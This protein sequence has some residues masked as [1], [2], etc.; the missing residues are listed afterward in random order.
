MRKY[1]LAKQIAII[2]ALIIS[3]APH[4]PT[5]LLEGQ[6]TY[7]YPP[8]EGDSWV[9]AFGDVE[10]D[11]SFT[12]THNIYLDI[13]RGT[14]GT[15]ILWERS[16]SVML[17]GY[18][19]Y[20][21]YTIL[22]NWSVINYR[23]PDLSI[24]IEYR[25]PVPYVFHPRSPND[26]MSI[27]SSL[28]LYLETPNGT[29]VMKGSQA[30][31]Y[32]V[33]GTTWIIYN[34]TMI[35]AYVVQQYTMISLVNMEYNISTTTIT[36]GAYI[37]NNSFKLP[38]VSEFTTETSY[39][40]GEQ[41]TSTSKMIL[42]S[43]RIT[44]DPLVPATQKPSDTNTTTT[45][46]PTT[47]AKEVTTPTPTETYTSVPSPTATIPANTIVQTYNLLIIVSKIGNYSGPDVP[48]RIRIQNLANGDTVALVR[49]NGTYSIKLPSSTYVLSIE[50]LEGRGGDGAYYYRF[51]EWKIPVDGASKT[52]QDPLIQVKLDRDLAIT[53]IVEVYIKSQSKVTPAQTQT[54]V[55]TTARDTTTTTAPNLTR[56]QTA[57]VEPL[58]TARSPIY[59]G[60]E[61]GAPQIPLEAP[62]KPWYSNPIIIGSIAG[63][64][65][66]AL[67][68]AIV[69][70]R[71]N[72]K[73]GG[74][75]EI[76]VLDK[77]K[78]AQQPPA[79]HSAS[80]Q[81]GRELPQAGQPSGASL[82]I[83]SRCGASNPLQARF[84]RQCGAELL[85]SKD[86]K[87]CPRCGASIKQGARFCPRCGSPI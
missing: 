66:A 6:A 21:N 48:V 82:Q 47:T 3:I 51:V 13:S 39:S 52:Y 29:M 65:A 56:T 32:A 20:A 9:Y 17:E 62:E 12:H 54:G 14:G 16:E 68:A 55:I 11:G 86:A 74:Y 76:D 63:G 1:L 58:T 30:T 41:I 69:L 25:P 40:S 37:I 34:D 27:N 59:G 28:T 80:A 8:V 60:G 78:H 50:E 18:E 45:A 87:S 64:G 4:L 77:T 19:S 57:A 33:N 75:R 84:C 42:Q 46:S 10:E 26:R 61:T 24:A 22:S 71:R 73:Q 70:R 43:Y 85:A 31:S 7:P 44:P 23:M 79:P 83:C 36:R 81:S 2:I 5:Q 35:Q 67:A 15:Y 49:I 53:I 72:N 38:F